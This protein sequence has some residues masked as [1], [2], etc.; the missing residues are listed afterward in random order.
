[1]PAIDR[2]VN[3]PRERE[4]YQMGVQFQSLWTGSGAHDDSGL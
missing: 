2:V 4:L 1:M 3:S